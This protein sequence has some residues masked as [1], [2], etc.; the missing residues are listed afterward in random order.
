MVVPTTA[1]FAAIG[2]SPC[3]TLGAESPHA[4]D[5]SATPPY[6]LSLLHLG[7]VDPLDDGTSCLR[8]VQNH[9][10]F[11]RFRQRDTT[12]NVRVG[13]WTTRKNFRASKVVH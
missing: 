12:L 13:V 2:F 1:R 10:D 11:E 6:S 4:P 3:Q 7:G 5:S 9:S 8:F